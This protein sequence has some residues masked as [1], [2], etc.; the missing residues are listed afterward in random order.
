[1][2]SGSTTKGRCVKYI[3]CFI[4]GVVVTI[5]SYQLDVGPVPVGVFEPEK[6]EEIGYS[7]Y[8]NLPN[9][10]ITVIENAYGGAAEEAANGVASLHFVQI[11]AFSEPDNAEVFREQAVS[12]GY[13]I[14][15]IFVQAE[16]GIFKVLI[17]PFAEEM[18]AELAVSWAMSKRFSGVITTKETSND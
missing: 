15:D 13:L 16:D 4:L 9:S 5:L 11:G 8:D 10:S 14:S 17:G 12:E 18:E 7:F 3:V 2:I 6:V 1:M